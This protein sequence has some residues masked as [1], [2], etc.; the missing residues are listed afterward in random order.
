[1]AAVLFAFMGGL[2]LGSAVAGRIADRLRRPLLVYAVLEGLIGVLG[3]LVPF[4]VPF[5]SSLMWWLTPMLGDSRPLGLAARFVLAAGML[6]VPTTL[7]G[8]T[9]PVLSR[10]FVEKRDRLGSSLAWLYAMNTFGAVAGAL[11]AGFILLPSLGVRRTTLV[12]ALANVVVMALALA[13]AR[14][15]G[16]SA[17]TVAKETRAA[18]LSMA[19]WMALLAIGIAG[20]ASMTDQIA[21]TRVLALCLGSSVYAFS[22]MVGTF[23]LGLALGSALVGRLLDGLKQPLVVLALVEA[24]AGLAVLGTVLVLGRFPVEVAELV[25]LHASSFSRL[26]VEEAWRVAVVLVV[27]TALMGAAFPLATLVFAGRDR[28]VA[29][30]VGTVYAVNTAGAIVGTLAG[31]FILLPVLGTRGALVLSALLNGVA[32]VLCLLPGFRGTSVLVKVT[33]LGSLLALPLVALSLPGWDP[34]VLTSGPFLYG[35]AY[36]QGGVDVRTGLAE[37]IE[38]QELLFFEDGITATVTVTRD[39]EEGSIA[40]AVNGKVDAST[41]TDMPT[42]L[43]LGHLPILLLEEPARKVLVVGLGSGATLAATLRH[44]EVERADCVEISGSIIEAARLHFAT[45]NDGVL[46]KGASDRVRI[47]EDDARSFVTLHR[48]TYDVIT[49][50]PSNPWLA[51]I[52]SLFSTEFFGLCQRILRPGGLMCQWIHSRGLSVEDLCVVLRTFLDA[53]PEVVVFETIPAGDYLLIGCDRRISVSASRLA[54]KMAGSKVRSSL[55]R[56]GMATPAGLLST[57]IAGREELV[58]FAGTGPLHTDDNGY[59]EFAAPR[60]LLDR[61][62]AEEQGRRLLSLS[63]SPVDRIDLGSVD[64]AE[65]Q[66]FLAELESRLQARRLVR[67]GAVSLRQGDS[68]RAEELLSAASESLPGDPFVRDSLLMMKLDRARRLFDEGRTGPRVVAL[69]E[70]A[71]RIDPTDGKPQE[72]L[73][74]LALAQGDLA[75]S[76]SFLEESVRLRPHNWLAWMNLGVAH[77]RREDTSRSEDCLREAAR[78]T[79]EPVVLINLAGVLL[80][81]DELGEA[82]KLYEAVLARKPGELEAL[83]GIVFILQSQGRIPEAIEF[84]RSSRKRVPAELEPQVDEWIDLLEGS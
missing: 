5:L 61:R 11:L 66:S 68:A 78:L 62:A 50:E 23:I 72:L 17:G 40:L 8:A 2:M 29:R 58:A 42:Q 67:E 6:L 55:E 60:S 10:F 26:L 3:L 56:I 84:L 14:R 4:T 18:P 57:F 74:Y 44:E 41:A 53:F 64:A 16:P 28:S 34:R 1:V 36:Q 38:R 46:E 24:L 83:Q 27:P 31:G 77:L 43:L 7:M 47:H 59:L 33:T 37:E 9:L 75:N 80:R 69:A 35:A 73:G 65:G 22:I 32:A 30:S 70:E 21:W 48:G 81:R 52:G 15:T 39:R 45:I 54:E 25:A 63:G 51:G 82:R 19:A 49:S 71:L 76:V 79:S 20:A 12:A 13:A